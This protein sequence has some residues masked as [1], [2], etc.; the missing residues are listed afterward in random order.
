M[1]PTVTTTSGGG[2]SMAKLRQQLAKIAQTD[3]YVGVPEDETNRNSGAMTNAGL[4][5]IHTHG[6]ALQHIPA[7]PVLE[8]AIEAPDNAALI[9]KQLGEAA[10]STLSAKPGDAKDHLNQAG[11]LA[12]NAAIR[13]FVDPRNGW[14]PNAPS[15]IA[16]K[17]SDR[18]LINTAQ[19]RRSITFLVEDE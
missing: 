1:Q 12:R 19:M 10:R 9:T 13:W 2:D 5:Y 16:E 7:R 3:V 8:P 4:L 15:T 11:M 6:S 17:G 18:P 14:A